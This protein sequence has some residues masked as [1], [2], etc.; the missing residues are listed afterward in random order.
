MTN[1]DALIEKYDGY[2]SQGHSI[3]TVTL[4][5]YIKSEAFAKSDAMRKFWDH[6][7]IYRVKT[8]LPIKAK[9]D[10]DW[11][12]EVSPEGSYHYHGFIC[13]EDKYKTKLWNSDGLRK[14]LIKSLDSFKSVGKYRQFRVNKYLIE[15]AKDIASW[16]AYITKQA[17]PFQ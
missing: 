4:S 9:I 10:Y 8:C 14:K 1:R 6:H 11:V 12:L 7:F 13:L 3:F 5:T 17:D 2:K 15:P 16:C